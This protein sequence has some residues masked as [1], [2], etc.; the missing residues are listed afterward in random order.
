MP[1]PADDGRLAQASKLESEV[2]LA[3]R[4]GDD[5]QDVWS[6]NVEVGPEAAKFAK[7][8]SWQVVKAGDLAKAP[9]AHAEGESELCL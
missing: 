6:A 2:Q 9:R 5:F 4:T 7:L 3:P 8:V 1:A